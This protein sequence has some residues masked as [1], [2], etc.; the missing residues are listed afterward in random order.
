MIFISHS[1]NDKHFALDL[2]QWLLQKGYDPAQVFLDSDA[3]SGIQAGAD[4]KEAL[5]D[6]LKRCSALIVLYSNHWRVSDWCSY[7]LGHARA[8]GKSIFPILIENIPI[9]GMAGE[10]QA[11][12]LF[13]DR[14]DALGRLWRSL[15]ENHLGPKDTFLW[16]HPG[17]KDDK[18]PFPGLPAF[19][20][21]YAAVYFGR[22]SETKEVLD[23][24]RKMRSDGEPRLLMIIGGSGTGKSSLLRAGALPRVVDTPDWIVLPTLRFGES[25]EDHTL[26]DQLVR[27]VVA[28]F[29]SDAARNCD[30]KKLRD[31]ITAENS[32]EAAK[33]FLDVTQELTMAVSKKDATVLIAIDQFEEMLSPTVGQSATRFLR[34]LKAVF[35]RKNGRLLA[36][37]TMRSDYLD[38]YEKHPEAMRTPLIHSWRLGP[39]PR[40]RMPEV[41]TKPAERAGIKI[42]PD[43]LAQ[44]IKDTPTAEA[45]PLLAF[46]LEKLYRRYT[47]DGRLEL[48]DYTTLGGME[49]AIQKSVEQIVPENTPKP[50]LDALRLVF[51]KH[52]AEV[53]D[54]DQVVRLTTQWSTLPV[55]AHPILEELVKERL[56]VKSEN[57][58]VEVAHEAMFRC[59]ERLKIWLRGSGEVMRWRR[60]VR[61]EREADM[62]KWRGLRGVRLELASKWPTTRGEEL[63]QEEI[64]WIKRGIFWKRLVRGGVISAVLAISVLALVALLLAA[65]ASNQRDQVK[66]Q[67]IE[68]ANESKKF[69]E[70]SERASHNLARS[71]I[72]SAAIREQ[73]NSVVALFMLWQAY[74]DAPANDPIRLSALRLLGGSQ[75][76]LP[77]YHAGEVQA[78]AFSPDGQTV[79]TG[80]DDK[81]AR[82]WDAKAGDRLY[83]PLVHNGSV[84][85]VAF[86][87]D[88]QT[89]LTG[90]GDH[91]ARLW[92][93]KTGAQRHELTH[94]GP[95]RAVAFSPDG[96][97]VL[98]GSD[99]NAAR[100]WEVKTGT[101]LHELAHHGTVRAV[102]FSPDG[103][104]V[105]TGSDDKTAQL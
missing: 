47:G 29:P 11:A 14:A 68:V 7:E 27:N 12:R 49:G 40:E 83:E 63:D 23:L 56:L 16:P 54:K 71:H 62:E 64:G 89:V 4:W 30:W 79:L 22:E 80:S 35:S 37:S 18:C 73:K 99:D 43:L 45:L 75:S 58:R 61:R 52:L 50:V 21:R 92:D 86:S 57:D 90:S 32:E 51:V 76:S 100:L 2:H 41:I 46:T 95:V 53:N 74:D 55:V 38:V 5:H 25:S 97:T 94:H 72:E 33:Q 15:Q 93:A 87:P 60:D 85:A 70:A 17:L 1:T 19:D 78:V 105:L 82:L 31:T 9:V 101:L 69:K 34:F 36:I 44:L 26:F 28:A 24:L 77:F 65:E 81:T 39:F 48:E 103:Q 8:T 88:G 3:D 96:Q 20:E 59:W 67:A 84:R 6:G 13:Q 10:Y 66:K 91:T 98:T 104:T 102:A 42:Q